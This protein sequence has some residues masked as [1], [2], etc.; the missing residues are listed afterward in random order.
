MAPEVFEEKYSFK[1]DVW[2]VGCVLVQMITGKAPWMG[3]G[4]TNPVSL[5]KH[6]KGRKGPPAVE[7]PNGTEEM[8][9]IALRQLLIK[10]FQQDPDARPTATELLGDPL[11]AKTRLLIA[12]DDQSAASQNLFSP[13]SDGSPWENLRSPNVAGS[14]S[15]RL[16][17]SKSIGAPGSPFLSPPLP[18]RVVTSHANSPS[19]HASPQPDTSGW[20][21]WARSVKKNQE[22][23]PQVS[24]D[25]LVYSDSN[26][27]STRRDSIG[28]SS[29][30]GMQFLPDST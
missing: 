19:T 8:S 15:P 12:E 9:G 18:K 23:S 3:M 13:G 16:A 21:A 29:L 6:V 4:F 26:N 5:F 17:R 25:S 30:L 7:L 14:P 20:P 22:V 2:S 11:F 28:S 1:A 24:E 27:G 10:C